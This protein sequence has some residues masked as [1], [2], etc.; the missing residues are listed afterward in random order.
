MIWRIPGLLLK[1]YTLKKRIQMLKY[2]RDRIRLYKL[3][4]DDKFRDAE[5]LALLQIWEL[6]LEKDDQRFEKLLNVCI[7][8]SMVNRYII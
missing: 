5:Q 3:K 6:F 7:Y 1:L 2:L 8:C 4:K